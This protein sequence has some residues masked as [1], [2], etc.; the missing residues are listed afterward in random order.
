MKY[1]NNELHD[2]YINMTREYL[3]ALRMVNDGCEVKVI[4]TQT[5]IET[6]EM[7]S[8]MQFDNFYRNFLPS[9]KRELITSLRILQKDIVD[10]V[11]YPDIN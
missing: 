5:E 4:L 1:A 8:E 9:F 6:D 2:D 7:A 11:N 10:A 3:K